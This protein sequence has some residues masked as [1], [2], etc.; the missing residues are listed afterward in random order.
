MPNPLISFL[1]AALLGGL[2]LGVLVL[3]TRALGKT[4][5]RPQLA[6]LSLGVM[7][8]LGILALGLFIMSHQPWFAKPWALGGVLAPFALFVLWQGLQ[9][10]RRKP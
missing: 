6:L 4:P 9:L 5:G 7:L 2:D 1:S 8:K 3:F 10:Q